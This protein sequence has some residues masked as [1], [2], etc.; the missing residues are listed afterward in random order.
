L[1]SIYYFYTVKYSSI[2]NTPQN[3]YTARR[4][5]LFISYLTQ[6]IVF[7]GG[8]QWMFPASFNA[9]TARCVSWYVGWSVPKQASSRTN[10]RS[11][12]A[13]ASLFRPWSVL[14]LETS[15][16]LLSLVSWVN[17]GCWVGVVNSQA[18]NF[19]TSYTL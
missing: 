5:L 15:K 4:A 9:C 17:E 6:Q 1:S 11:A 2:Q 8:V 14:S 16:Y 3:R 10:A 12:H 18:C 13:S 19:P 7:L